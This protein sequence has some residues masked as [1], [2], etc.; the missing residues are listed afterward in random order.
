MLQAGLFTQ[1]KWGDTLLIWGDAADIDDLH[2]NL[3]ALLSGGQA[4][5]DVAGC[6]LDSQLR[7]VAAAEER[8][9]S[10]LVRTD[11]GLQW[12]CSR[13]VIEQTEALVAAL[14]L[15][16]TGHQYVDVTG[17]LATQA[18]VAKGEYPASLRP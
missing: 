6:T 12:T 11:D 13:P 1:F 7:I 16:A 3:R 8:Q 2:R 18:M 9:V 14:R 15:A 17:P 5:L 4:S 10:E